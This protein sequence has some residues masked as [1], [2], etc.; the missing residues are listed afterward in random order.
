MTTRLLR[1][2]PLPMSSASPIGPSARPFLSRHSALRIALVSAPAVRR[3]NGLVTNGTASPTLARTLSNSDILH[4]E[5]E[6]AYRA[7]NSSHA[8]QPT[9]RSRRKRR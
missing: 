7:K 2:N 8:G 6:A 3:R 4:T 9:I 1:L 5:P